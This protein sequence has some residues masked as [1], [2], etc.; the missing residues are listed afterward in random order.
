MSKGYKVFKNIYSYKWLNKIQNRNGACV[1]EQKIALSHHGVFNT[2]RKPTYP[3]AR[4]SWPLKKMR[5]S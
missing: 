3:E 2:A 5:T 4:F 1:K